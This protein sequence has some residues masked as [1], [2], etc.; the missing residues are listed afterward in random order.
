[1]VKI[2]EASTDANAIL[3]EVLENGLAGISGGRVET[4]NK[5][6]LIASLAEE[7]G[8]KYVVA[9]STINHMTCELAFLY[10]ASRYE[11]LVAKRTVINAYNLA[12][13]EDPKDVL[14]K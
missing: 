6:G 11:H 13:T 12:L 7:K 4:R 5:L 3:K 1:M 8:H 2:F 10:D 14:H 9:R